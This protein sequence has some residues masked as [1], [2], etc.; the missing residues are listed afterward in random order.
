MTFLDTGFLFA[1]VSE[2]DKGHV[3]VNEVLGVYR[4][5]R[6]T[7]LLLTTNREGLTLFLGGSVVHLAAAL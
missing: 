4:G 6:L 2:N 3:R 1:Y 7:D 5:H